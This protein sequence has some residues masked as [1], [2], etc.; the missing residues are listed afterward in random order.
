MDFSQYLS[1]CVSL[2][3][4]LR[5]DVYFSVSFSFFPTCSGSL[6]ISFSLCV[7]YGLSIGLSLSLFLPVSISL[8][9]VSLGLPVCLSVYPSVFQCIPCLHLSLPLY[10]FLCLPVCLLVCF[11]FLPFPPSLFLLVSCCPCDSLISQ[12]P[13][14][15]CLLLPLSTC[16]PWHPG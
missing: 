5:L 1:L 11:V 3:L 12:G 4:P 14:A 10:C 6:R 8:V 15:L 9:C 13:S 2:Y 16:Y 7:S